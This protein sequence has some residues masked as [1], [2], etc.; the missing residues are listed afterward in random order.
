MLQPRAPDFWWAPK[1][2]LTI[3]IFD[4]FWSSFI[5]A[6]FWSIN[7]NIT[8][9]AVYIGTIVDLALFAAAVEQL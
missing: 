9:Y 4:L 5:Y 1:W 7:S 3:I 2:N 6:G 8:I